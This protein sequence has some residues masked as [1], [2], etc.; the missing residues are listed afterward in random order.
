MEMF[1]LFLFMVVALCVC[2]C[3]FVYVCVCLCIFEYFCSKCIYNWMFCD[4]VDF[5]GIL[6][7]CGFFGF[8]DFFVFF[9]FVVL[10]FSLGTMRFFDVFGFW[11]NFRIFVDF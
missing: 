2:L 1:C 11:W 4:F 10:K 5:G 3:M 7:F 8:V 9:V 6:D